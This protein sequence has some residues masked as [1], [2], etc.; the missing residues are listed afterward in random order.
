VRITVLVPSLELGGAER[1]VVKFVEAIRADVDHVDIIC[2]AR[3][4]ARVLGELAPGMKVQVMS[5]RSTANPLLWL[6]VVLQLRRD[7]PDVIVGWSTYA[8]LVAALVS[9]VLPG[10]RVVLSERNYVPEVFRRERTTAIRR[11]VVLALMRLM[12]SKADVVTANSSDNVRFLRKFVGGGTC[13]RRLPNCI[14]VSRSDKLAA[15]EAV[16]PTIGSAGPRLLAIGRLVAQKGFDSL[17]EAIARV[18]MHKPW[19]LV[20]V[21]DGPEKEALVLH[22]ERLGLA[23]AIQWVRAVANP[24]PYYRWA[25]IVV[26]PSRYE[27]FPN[28][29]LEAMASGC[30][31]IASDCRTGPRELTERG[32]FGVLVPVGD[33]AALADAILDLGADPGRCARL[34]AAA[35][36]HVVDVYDVAAVRGCYLDLVTLPK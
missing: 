15:G 16:L 17:L 31:V 34:G 33:V 13:Y 2:M 21:G 5:A 12:Y 7:Q 18:R 9:R 25:D 22:S 30:A 35:R 20:I 26:M 32:R 36:N 10:S 8:N 11:R 14:D 24:F 29:L 19:E 28:V 3:A 4:D 1:S 23:G 27:G 6:N